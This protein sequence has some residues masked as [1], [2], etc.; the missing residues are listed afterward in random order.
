MLEAIHPICDCLIKGENA[1]G[2]GDD[3]VGLNC[4]SGEEGLLNVPVVLNV[5]NDGLGEGGKPATAA[6]ATKGLEV[7]AVVDLRAGFKG[8]GLF[9]ISS[10]RA[11][12][13]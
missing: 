7:G 5:A 1:D 9:L 3:I 6:A 12:V 8:R 10:P 11:D 2:F 4:G 13:E